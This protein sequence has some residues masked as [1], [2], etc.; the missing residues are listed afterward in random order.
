M[1]RWAMC[2]ADS[3]ASQ[4]DVAGGFSEVFAV[5]DEV[6]FMSEKLCSSERALLH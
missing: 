3:A 1:E 5:K 4:V 2:L 6:R